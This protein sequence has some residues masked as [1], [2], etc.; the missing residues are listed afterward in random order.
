MEFTRRQFLGGALAGGAAT[1]I[2]LDMLLHAARLA[3]AAGS[4][5]FTPAQYA[6]CA[7][8]CSRIVPTGADPGAAEAHAVDF[9][10]FFLAAFELPQSV[11]DHPAIYLRGRFS[12]R[13][14]YPD[15]GTGKPSSNYP[16]S[17]FVDVATG[18]RHFLP[19]TPHQELSW[20]LQLYGP[21][22]VVDDPSL[23]K[24]FRDAVA[25][26][27]IPTPPPLRDTYTAGLA[28]FD[29]Y[30]TSLFGVPFAAASPSEQDAMLLAA[31]NPVLGNVPLPPIAPPAAA[32]ALFPIVA[33]HTFMGCFGLPEYG[34]NGFD[35]SHPLERHPP[36]W[37]WIRWDGD[38]LP[39]GNSVYDANLG[40]DQIAAG[41]TPAGGYQ[42]SNAGFGDP[43]VYQPRGGYREYR[44]VSTNAGVAP[45][46]GAGDVAPLVDAVRSRR[47]RPAVG[48]R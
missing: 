18:Q 2:P 9:I 8:I 33:T 44:P 21:K 36:M 40:D 24:A 26:G 15:P 39:L 7:A 38:T 10:D 13:H 27:L 4:R 19:L 29:A 17:D 1:A 28:A 45:D 3:E 5:F 22:V 43:A 32:S 37:T 30:S 14:P 11:A 25:S 48:R 42:G 35:P 12:G 16:S 31:S 20:R 6:T 47:W 41:I 46:L 23:P 34:G